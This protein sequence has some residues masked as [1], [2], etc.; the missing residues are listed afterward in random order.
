MLI[1]AAK[2]WV[3]FTDG[4]GLTN[5]HNWTALR[6]FY[7]LFV[8][9]MRLHV[10]PLCWTSC[11]LHNRR[12]HH[13]NR[14]LKQHLQPRNKPG[15]TWKVTKIKCGFP[16][17]QSWPIFLQ[18]YTSK[19][20]G[21]KRTESIFRNWKCLERASLQPSRQEN[22]TGLFHSNFEGMIQMSFHIASAE[23]RNEE[24]KQV[25]AFMVFRTPTSL[26]APRRAH[27]VS[28]PSTNFHLSPVSFPDTGS[29]VQIPLDHVSLQTQYFRQHLT[30]WSLCQKGFYIC[31]SLANLCD[32]SSC[33][34]KRKQ[35]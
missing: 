15:R 32:S 10:C 8:K 9:S 5:T 18:G 16:P 34:E 29:Y 25:S 28:C 22:R 19:F 17:I 30:K 4:H 21:P 7:D 11:G 35:C 12:N 1:F 31:L 2:R 27:P 23:W 13:Q 24:W 6:W 20:Q 14:N 3:F 26:N 33:R